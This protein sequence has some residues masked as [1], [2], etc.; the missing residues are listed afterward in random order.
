[1]KR[2]VTRPAILVLGVFTAAS[3]IGQYNVNTTASALAAGGGTGTVSYNGTQAGANISPGQGTI[4]YTNAPNVPNLTQATSQ[5]TVTYPTSA[6][7]AVAAAYATA[8]LAWGTLGALGSGTQL[9]A[10]N[11]SSGN[12]TASMSDT[13]TFH[14]S[15]ATNST[16]TPIAVS[17]QVTGDVSS[18]GSSFGFLRTSAMT[19]GN[20]FIS[21]SYDAS[22][23][24]PGKIVE[25]QG[26]V[27]MQIVSLTDSLFWV[28]GVYALTGP[29]PTL[30][31]TMSLNVQCQSGNCDFI[32]TGTFTMTPPAGVTYASA[33][34]VFLTQ[35]PPVC[36]VVLS[37]GG[38]TFP[39]AGGSGTLGVIMPNG[40]DWS[41][42]GAPSWLAISGS[43][44]GN[45]NGS[46]NYHLQANAGGDRF[47]LLTVNG[48]TFIVEQQA[49]SIAGLN[50]IGSLAHLAAEE[51]WTTAFTL[52]NKGSATSSIRLNFSGDAADPTGNGP[53]SLPLA[54]PQIAGSSGALLADSLDRTITGNASLI[55]DTAGAQSP[56]VL[57]GSAQLAAS[58]AVDG[59]AIFH[60]I[61]TTQEAVVPMETRN[62]SS[63]LLPFD[64]TNG[65]VLGV[66]VENLSA[67]NAVIPVII[68]DENGVVISAPGASIS[69]GGN[70]HTSFV[71][72]DPALGFPVTAEIRGT[73]EFDTPPGGQISALGLRFTPPNNALTTI[74]ALAN[75]G[76]GGGSIAH[77]ASGGDGWQTTFVLVN[78][79]TSSAQA[80]LSFF[81]DQTGA[82]LSLPLSFPQPSGGAPTVAPSITKNLAAGAT[83]VIVSS[84][85]ASLLTGSAQL[86]TAGNI[87]GFV[88]FRHNN[89]EAVV[90]LESRNAGGYIIAFDNTN[91]TATGVALNAVS[92]AQVNVPVVVRNDEGTPIANDTITLAPNGHFAFTLGSDR[93][94]AALTIRGTIEFDTPAG[95]QI[96]ALGIR[97]PGGA[98]HTY[99]T[100]P[101]LAK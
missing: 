71:L 49:A 45:G 95:A 21:E 57:V 25:N 6:G 20:A 15:G 101:A 55:I 43:G 79:G 4:N 12:A 74:P 83:L 9:S 29:N 100:L 93:Y 76:T 5:L 81:N 7:T 16:V 10:S 99:T 41:V 27:S 3:A 62:A 90:P 92:A 13:L 78:T 97:I 33:S 60:Q 14:V 32:H 24:T 68:R 30:P 58:G 82:P 28:N 26:W 52:I 84:G 73:I 56:P 22:K 46:V 98:A 39:A 69:L 37:S 59:F 18:N 91:G 47:A 89:Q 42:S 38:Q 88:I 8:N 67:S 75:V 40:C 80:T 85:A 35:P 31:F 86:A 53:L 51:N 36:N 64:N 23:A 61:V 63:Y 94:P 34:G 1:M 87:S 48:T 54:F 72:S 17:F 50:F 2:S 66:A 44:S 70:G 19:M 77:L 11:N 96:G 65:L